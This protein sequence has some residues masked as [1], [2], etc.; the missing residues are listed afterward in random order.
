MRKN[1]CSSDP[2]CKK[3]NKPNRRAVTDLRLNVE[4]FIFMKIIIVDK[5]VTWTQGYLWWNH[6]LHNL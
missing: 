5:A 6:V 4:Y 1:Y 3:D 2:T